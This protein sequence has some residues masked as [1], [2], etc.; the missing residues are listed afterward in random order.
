VVTICDRQDTVPQAAVD[1]LIWTAQPNG[2]RYNNTCKTF[3]R[4]IYFFIQ[5]RVL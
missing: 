4:F 2:T 5:T 1:Q 3:L